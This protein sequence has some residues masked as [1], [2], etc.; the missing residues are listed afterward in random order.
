MAIEGFMNPETKA[1]FLKL[2]LALEQASSS[3]HQCFF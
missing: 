1:R 2:N 3:E